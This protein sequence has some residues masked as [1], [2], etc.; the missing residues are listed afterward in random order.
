MNAKFRGNTKLFGSR[1]AKPA[2]SPVG[3][4]DEIPSAS[5]L[6]SFSWCAVRQTIPLPLKTNLNMTGE[7]GCDLHG[8]KTE[9]LK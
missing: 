8:D 3:L 4:I 2:A 6:K 1:R 7:G 9:C 5:T